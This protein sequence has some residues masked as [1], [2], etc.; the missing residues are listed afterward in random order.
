MSGW[1]GFLFYQKT[2]KFF[3][4]YFF[5]DVW[6]SYTIFFLTELSLWRIV[7]NFIGFI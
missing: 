6:Q 5:L 1:Q 7:D 2:S 3:H 4:F